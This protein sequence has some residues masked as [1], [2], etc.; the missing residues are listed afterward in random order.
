MFL[1]MTLTFT[2][3]IRTSPLFF[4]SFKQLTLLAQGMFSP[5]MQQSQQQART[6]LPDLAPRF[7]HQKPTNTPSTVCERPGALETLHMF[8]FEGFS[9][10]SLVRGVS[11]ESTMSYEGN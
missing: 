1:G 9:K 5:E 2:L 11:L 4:A 6:T 7:M 3:R 10:L 8:A